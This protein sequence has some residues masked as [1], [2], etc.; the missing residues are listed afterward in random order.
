MKRFHLI[1]FFFVIGFFIN[2]TPLFGQYRII[3]NVNNG[4]ESPSDHGVREGSMITLNFLNFERVDTA[5]VQNNRFIFSGKIPYP[6]IATIEYEYGGHVILLDSAVYEFELTL[7]R[8]GNRLYYDSDIRTKSEFYTTWLAFIESLDEF[9]IPKRQYTIQSENSKDND[10]ILFY[11]NELKKIDSKLANHYWNFVNECPNKYVVAFIAP[12]APDFSYDKYY[13]IYEGLPDS[14]KN[15]F[16]GENLLEQLN[17][18]KNSV[19]NQK[20]EVL[21]SSQRPE[22]LIGSQMPEIVAVDTTL[23]KVVLDKTFYQKQ[24]YT[25]IDF[26]ASWCAPCRKANVDYKALERDFKE[27]S[28]VIVG[29]SLDKSALQWKNAIIKDNTTWLHISDLMGEKS[30]TADYFKIESIPANLI[31]DSSGKI[32]GQNISVKELMEFFDSLE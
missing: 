19:L 25:I 32:V 23:Q 29:F 22:I 5:F 21:I 30:P 20:E 6:S 1:G 4:A 10:S 16:Y 11:Q 3:G 9:E 27:Q 28:I 7:K 13:S 26:W 14:L 8:D 18:S 17:A 2:Y 31:I 24:R 15:T 12:G